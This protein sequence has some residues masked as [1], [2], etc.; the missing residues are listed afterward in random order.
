VG[1]AER[2]RLNESAVDEGH[3]SCTKQSNEK[4]NELAW[5]TSPLSE[6]LANAKTPVG[7]EPNPAGTQVIVARPLNF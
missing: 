2:D 1:A 6:D 7:A 5:Y 3:S 4:K